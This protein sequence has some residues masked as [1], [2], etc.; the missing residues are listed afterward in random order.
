MKNKA[1]H[2]EVT[3][4]SFPLD[5]D[6]FFWKSTGEE[7]QIKGKRVGLEKRTDRNKRNSAGA[8]TR[9]RVR[10]S[11]CTWGFLGSWGK[12]DEKE[13]IDWES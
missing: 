6:F 2:Q 10:V 13:I 1:Q 9:M 3:S 5:G 11:L 8:Q 4:L 7:E 12:L